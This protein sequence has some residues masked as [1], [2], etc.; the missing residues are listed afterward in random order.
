M[1]CEIAIQPMAIS[2]FRRRALAPPGGKA[3]VDL[4]TRKPMLPVELSGVVALRESTR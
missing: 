3:Q 2:I 1:G 4:A